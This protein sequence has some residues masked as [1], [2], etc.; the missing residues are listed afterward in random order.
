ML[1]PKQRHSTSSRLG[2]NV[3]NHSFS[4]SVN[5]GVHEI[6]SNIRIL[7]VVI[8]QTQFDHQFG[9]LSSVSFIQLHNSGLARRILV[10]QEIVPNHVQIGLGNVRYFLPRRHRWI[11]FNHAQQLVVRLA[12][13]NHSQSANGS[14][15]Q[16]QVSVR[17]RPRG[18]Y[19]HVDGIIYVSRTI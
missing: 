8:L 4:D 3:R 16:Q 1:L 12:T 15:S 10:R 9:F 2:S 5:Q 13:I 19:T 18:K 11:S 14:R 7:G 17:E 6:L